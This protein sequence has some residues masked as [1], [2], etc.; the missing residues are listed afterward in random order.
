[1]SNVWEKYL[2]P[3]DREVYASAGFGVMQG[4]G[5]NPAIIVVDV[6][7]GF[8]GEKDVPIQE[9]INT[10][11]ASSGPESWQAVSQMKLLIEAYREIE[12]GIPVFYTTIDGYPN[13]STYK[14]GVKA[15]LF[16]KPVMHKGER[17]AQIVEEIKPT[18]ND[19]VISKMKPSAFFGTSLVS[20]LNTFNVDSVI[21]V[22]CTTS[23]CVRATVIDAFSY[24]YD[25][26]VPEECV[27]D[28]G[29]TT[30]AINLF[31]MQQKYADVISTQE[32]IKQL[33]ENDLS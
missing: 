9:S 11:P 14:V 30:H 29:I 18:E 7:Y 5:K 17:G 24:N 20:Y 10:Y 22:G 12:S 3:R 26:V 6:T 16:D 23:G 32:V 2:D 13:A 31:D 19:V 27:F 33:R 25:V 21:V 8:T 4:L 15:A 28:R 1:M